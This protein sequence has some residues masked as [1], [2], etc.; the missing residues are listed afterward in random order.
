MKFKKNIYLRFWFGAFKILSSL[1]YSHSAPDFHVKHLLYS[2]SSSDFLMRHISG[3]SVI[4][5]TYIRL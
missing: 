2:F 5:G 3:Y 4:Y 1:P